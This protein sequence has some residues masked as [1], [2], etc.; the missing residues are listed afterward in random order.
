[1]PLVEANGAAQE[2]LGSDELSVARAWITIADHLRDTEAEAVRLA[3]LT[4][5]AELPGGAGDALCCAAALHDVGKAHPAFQ[6]ML[7]G[8]APEDERAS[9]V[10][11]LW[12][13]SAF[14]GGR[15]VRPH[16]RHE[17]ASAL[18][19]MAADGTIAL[20]GDEPDLVCYLVAA[21]HGR[22]RLTIRS[23]PE[24]PLAENGA[25]RVLGI[26]EGD[27]LPGVD[28][29]LGRLPPCTLSLGAMELG[30]GGRGPSWTARA[31]A[32]RDRSDLG[33][34]RLAYLEALVRI[35]DWRASGA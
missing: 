30:G 23:A 12:A 2:A 32:L 6:S 20:A 10:G 16:F 25:A 31:C 26:E 28:T 27:E 33:P 8:T 5:D 18:G 35:A 1:V 21:H 15:H 14:P 4:A 3:G 9:L 17:L 24:E 22:V 13:K 34:F 11:F 7:R 29:P 19:V